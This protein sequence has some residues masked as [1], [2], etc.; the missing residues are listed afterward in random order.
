MGIS[1][2]TKPGP[3][4][5][6]KLLFLIPHSSNPSLDIIQFPREANPNVC[7]PHSSQFEIIT[8]IPHDLWIKPS[9][10][11][12]PQNIEKIK[13]PKKIPSSLLHFL[14]MLLRIVL[15]KCKRTTCEELWRR[16]WF[17]KRPSSTDEGGGPSRSIRWEQQPECPPKD[18]RCKHPVK[19]EDIIPA[20]VLHVC[21]STAGPRHHQPCKL[22]HRSTGHLY[23]TRKRQ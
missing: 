19:E 11:T 4:R 21:I 9:T 17:Q 6:P 20:R 8:N 13:C 3:N 2:W 23:L 1:I 18:I 7:T 5:M 12:T 15:G 10:S 16:N 22:L 14:L